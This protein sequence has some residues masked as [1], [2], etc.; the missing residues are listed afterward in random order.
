MTADP[1][2]KDINPW[3]RSTGAPYRA[4][5]RRPTVAARQRRRRRPPPH[6]QQADRCAPDGA[7]LLLGETVSV[8]AR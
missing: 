5:H 7:P 4:G 3:F 8:F 2:P 6:P 1:Q